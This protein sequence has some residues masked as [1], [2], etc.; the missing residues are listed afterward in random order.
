MNL[1]MVATGLFP[2]ADHSES[3]RK[4]R[5]S[6]RVLPRNICK[7]ALNSHFSKPKILRARGP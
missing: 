1:R 6:S 2:V 5:S 4:K 3:H 7:Q